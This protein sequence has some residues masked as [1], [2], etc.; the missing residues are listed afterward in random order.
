MSE[1]FD[2]FAGPNGQRLITE[3]LE[4]QSF[5]GG[6]LAERFAAAV[7]LEAYENGQ[8]IVEQDSTSNDFYVIL[9]GSVQIERNG[10]A[11]PTRTSGNHFGEM[12]VVDP[13]AKRSASVRALETCVV[14]RI[15]EPEFSSIAA[16]APHIWRTIA[17]ELAE[18]LRQ[19]LRDVPLKNEDTHIFIGSSRE[20]LAI[21]ETIRTCVSASSRRVSLWSEGVFA[22]SETNIESLER[23]VRAADI[24]V[25]VLSADDKIRSRKKSSRGPRDNVIFELG[26]FMGA[27]G[28]HRTFV[29]RPQKEMKVPTDL[30][31]V[32]PL[33]YREDN[34]ESRGLDLSGV[35]SEL[36]AAIE[37]LGPK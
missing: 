1:L 31:G 25:L 37:R 34:I 13:S 33:T 35:C 24:G 11:G 29:V 9:A 19:R 27:L 4:R 10:R 8:L 12:S 17:K 23:T 18:R 3:I 32:T 22:A 16:E 2:R 21:A 28:R 5:A 14:A 15:G 26:L 20:A 6:G 30:L 36:N 7:Q